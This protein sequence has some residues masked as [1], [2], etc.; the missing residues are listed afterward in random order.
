MITNKNILFKS[1]TFFS[2]LLMVFS[3]CAQQ[4][5][6]ITETDPWKRMELIIKGIPQTQFSDKIY[7]IKNYGA[8]ADG[9][10]LN[11]EAFRKAI[12]ACTENGGGKVLVPN[13][14]YLTGSIHLE[15]N[16]NLHL[17]DKAEILFSTDPKN[18]PLVHTSF[19]GTE[20]INYS[21]LIFARNKTNVAVTGKGTLNGQANNDNWWSWAGSKYYGWKKGV[22]SQNDPKNRETLV[23]MAEENVPVE[24][25][26]FGD[27][28]YLRPNFIEFFECN[29]VLIKDVTIIN[30]PFWILHP[31]KS[32]NV[33]VDGVTITSHGP[34][35]D[36]CD[37]EYS[38]NVLIKNC[39]FNTGDDCIAIKSGRDADGRRVG[40]PSKNIIVQNC[41][42]IDGHGGVVMGSEISAGVNNV[43]VENCI[44]DSP[45][46]E[47]A[48]RI[49]T[50]SKR[51]GTTEDIYVR[52]IEVGTV[53]EC[54]L[55]ATMFY[56]VYGSQNGDFI[57]TIKN[58]S[59][60][61]IKVKN[62]GKFGILA[63]GYEQSPIENITLKDVIIEK[64]D[65]VHSLKNVKNINFINTY[66]NGKKIEF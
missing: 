32:N 50:N 23:A 5:T 33:I 12:K 57:P 17:E 42:M 41:K 47:R 3:C 38:Q 18:Y 22:P 55:R 30:A 51:G 44:M 27:G 49:K 63:D 59:L 16:V 25:R 45:N 4:A 6:V 24:K 39:T 60:E 14:K 15:N 7:S 9:K 43:F 21:P 62:G 29:T 26:V 11:T 2:T 48:I 58:I 66:I 40:I 64:V 34:N 20:L 8:V 36:G 37:P 31:L 35:N 13:G 56:N 53:K 54:V 10:T 19:E 46:L 28:H 61:N 52:N 65:S 1:I